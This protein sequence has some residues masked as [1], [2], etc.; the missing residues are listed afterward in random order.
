MVSRPTAGEGAQE[1][2]SLK[3]R[4]VGD[5]AEPRTS[6]WFGDLPS[7]PFARGHGLQDY[8]PQVPNP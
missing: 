5:G 1:P 7:P 2:R 6:P 4:V 3:W 8:S